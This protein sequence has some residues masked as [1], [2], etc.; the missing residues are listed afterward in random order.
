MSDRARNLADQFGAAQSELIDT[1]QSI[2]DDKW[3]LTCQNDERSVGVMAH[4][5]GMSISGTFE[6]VRLAGTGQPVPPMSWEMINTMN[7]NHAIEYANVTKD[8]ALE[9]IRTNGEHV[10]K[11]IAQL[12]DETLDREILL[13]LIGQD[14]VTVESVIQSLV[15]GH[16]HM[17]LPDIKAT[18]A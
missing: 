11:E 17:H 2:P 1:V 7:A 13:P 9:C 6:A 10:Q 8:E 3:N 16:L 15:I 18:V 12:S 14:H 4:H 5:I